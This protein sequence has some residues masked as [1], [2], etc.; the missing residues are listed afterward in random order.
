[1][2]ALRHLPSLCRIPNLRAIQWQPG[3][4]HSAILQWTDV[5]R[6]ILDSGK[7]CQIYA[8]PEEVEPLVREV[9][10]DGL[11]VIT[12]GS[13]EEISRLAER[14]DLDSRGFEPPADAEPFHP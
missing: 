8:R 14:Y 5:I 10:G 11:M 3:D 1:M 9:G 6:T 2:Q 7:S 13:E 12:W 4:G